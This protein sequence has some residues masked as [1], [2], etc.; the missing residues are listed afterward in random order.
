VLQ[1]ANGAAVSAAEITVPIHRSANGAIYVDVTPDGFKER[2]LLDTGATD[3]VVRHDYELMGRVAK[4]TVMA[5]NQQRVEVE[6][7]STVVRIGGR[8]VTAPDAV[9]QRTSLTPIV[10]IT[11]LEQ[12]GRVMIDF[13]HNTLTL[14]GE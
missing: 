1:T 11:A 2:A 13:Q 12:F 5:F 4:G 3:A 14:E 10:P 8:C 6:Q 7:A 9:Y